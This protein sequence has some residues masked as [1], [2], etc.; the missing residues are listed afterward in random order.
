MSLSSTSPSASA[1]GT[2]AVIIVNWN[3]REELARCLQ[4]L[5]RAANHWPWGEVHVWVVDNASQD[6]SVLM[7]RARFPWVSLLPLEE[8]LGFAAANN[9][10]LRALGVLS[11][12]SSSLYTRSAAMAQRLSLP[13]GSTP[14]DTLLFLNPDTEVAPDALFRMGETLYANARTG[15]VGPRLM[16]PD[17]THQH[18]GFRFPNL[19]Q[20]F[21]D[22]FPIHGRLVH[23]RLNGRYAKILYE[24][25]APFPVDFVLGAAMMTRREVIETV[26]G[27]DEGY[28]LYCEEMDWA[29]RVR[30]AGWEIRIDP[31]ARVIH[32][33]GR[34]SRQFRGQAFVALW[35]SR[36]RY[37]RQYHSPWFNLIVRGLVLLGVWHLRRQ[38]RHLPPQERAARWAAYSKVA[39][40]AWTGKP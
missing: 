39:R 7:V 9:L 34:S 21:L 25:T 14:P 3:V 6:D 22:F 13:P 26:G 15:V 4:S 27:F 10:A 12:S 1:P 31:R 20:V 16:Y 8:N 17:G 28:W 18:S 29:R 2:L 24:G 32:Y 19:W 40:M 35:R 23:S 5:D 33:E 36:F 30:A 37:F 38:A 11:A